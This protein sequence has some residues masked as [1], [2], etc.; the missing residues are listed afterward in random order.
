MVKAARVQTRCCTI[1]MRFQT[2]AHLRQQSNIFGE[3]IIAGQERCR[4]AKILSSNLQNKSILLKNVCIMV[5]MKVSN[6][7]IANPTKTVRRD[8]NDVEFDGSFELIAI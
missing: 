3:S 8:G 4:L 7:A 2:N 1:I 5:L 6:P